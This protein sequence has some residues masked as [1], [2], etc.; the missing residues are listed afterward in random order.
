MKSI[1]R[2][3]THGI[4]TRSTTCILY[5]YKGLSDVNF[6]VHVRLPSSATHSKGS[7]TRVGPHRHLSDPLPGG[8]GNPYLCAKNIESVSDWFHASAHTALTVISFTATIVQVDESTST[9]VTIQHYSRIN[10]QALELHAQLSVRSEFVANVHT[11]L[12]NLELWQGVTP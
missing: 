2:D 7:A 4:C 11:F 8:H 6:H 3:C 5:R 9:Y 1:Y 10:H 12:P